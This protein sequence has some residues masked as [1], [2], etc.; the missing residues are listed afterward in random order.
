MTRSRSAATLHRTDMT[1]AKEKPISV[2]MG[3]N[4]IET[5]IRVLHAIRPPPPRR[6]E[7]APNCCV[8]QHANPLGF[9]P[10]VDAA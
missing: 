9:M 6:M 10:D 4:P 2:P 5:A 8:E 1:N 3:E 7:L